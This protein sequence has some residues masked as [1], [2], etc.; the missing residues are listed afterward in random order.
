MSERLP[1]FERPNGWPLALA[2]RGFSPEG[3]ENSAAAFR[4][5]LNLGF[6]HLET[7]VHATA[8]AVVV[9]FHDDTLDRITD[10]TGR[11]SELTATEIARAR[12]R[13]M[14]P[15]LLL[16]EA[17][18]AFPDARF[19]I[20][21]KTA[22]SIRPLAEAIER[23]AAHQRVLVASFSDRR[24]RAVLRLLTRPTASSA[25]IPTTV[26][27]KLLGPVLPD[28]L[29]RRVLHDVHAFQVPERY[30]VVQVV[31]PG[32]LRR[33]HRLGIEVHVWT[34]NDPDRMRRLLDLGVDAIVSDRADLLAGLLAERGQ[35][36]GVPQQ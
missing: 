5:A 16:E 23:H 35:W 13:G 21:V 27:F 30:R 18:T 31:T 6:T 20:D 25:G 2:H 28:W 8:D 11:I 4:A 14:E 36:P 33:A 10:S 19:N 29:L 3:L 1:F 34:V 7:D 9:L 15:V 32:F 26:L 24:R 17:L 22:N 12:I